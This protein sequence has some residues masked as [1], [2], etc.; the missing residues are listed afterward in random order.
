MVLEAVVHHSSA[1]ADNG[2][3]S[4]LPREQRRGELEDVEGRGQVGLVFVCLFGFFFVLCGCVWLLLWLCV[5]V[6]VCV[7]RRCFVCCCV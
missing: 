7:V 6:C 4:G 3:A 2:A 1:D 5:V